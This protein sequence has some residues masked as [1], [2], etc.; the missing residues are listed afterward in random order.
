MALKNSPDDLSRAAALSSNIGAGPLSTKSIR[1]T[2]L[3]DSLIKFTGD[4]DLS[5][6]ARTIDYIAAKNKRTGGGIPAATASLFG[7]ILYCSAFDFGNVFD[8]VKGRPIA[9]IAK[10]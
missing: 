10:A 9:F 3:E 1:G 7:D 8:M 6:S 2:F 4:S 5:S